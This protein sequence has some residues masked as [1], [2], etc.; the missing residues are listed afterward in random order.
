M[1]R[2]MIPD[3]ATIAHWRMDEI[4]SGTIV[5]IAG[6]TNADLIA[7]G[8]TWTG[9]GTLAIPVGA[10]VSDP[11]VPFTGAR[12]MTTGYGA[13]TFDN[14]GVRFRLPRLT[15]E[16]WVNLT[17]LTNDC[18]MLGCYDFQAGV[19]S[20]GWYWG[21]TTTKIWLATKTNGLAGT[22][23]EA[24]TLASGVLTTGV[25]YYIAGT[26]GDGFCRVYKNGVLAQAVATNGDH[27][28]DYA[29]VSALYH[30][31]TLGF[32]GKSSDGAMYPPVW[33]GK[34]AEVRVSNVVRTP[35]EI[36][37]TWNAYIAR[38]PAAG[39]GVET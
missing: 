31:F 4:G 18:A 22:W 21:Q 27:L 33:I 6:D 36:A 30:R 26:I 16:F 25:W 14:S 1:P 15:C 20:G 17:N 35:W 9:A 28:V 19:G 2:R 39:F 5:N 13:K 23:T 32:A 29:T 37:R 12:T 34:V 38:D 10:T 7:A 3:A 8:T 11:L 24:S